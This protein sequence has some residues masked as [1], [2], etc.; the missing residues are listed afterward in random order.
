L[1]YHCRERDD[2]RTEYEID[3]DSDTLFGFTTDSKRFRTRRGTRV[4]DTRKRAERKERRKGDYRLCGE[5]PGAILRE[6]D[7][8]VLYIFFYR[9][10]VSSIVVDGTSVNC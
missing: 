6:R 8:H 1:G 9:R 3:H 2:C 7:D 4:G 5:G 10:R